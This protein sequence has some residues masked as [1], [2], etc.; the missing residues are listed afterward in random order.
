MLVGHEEDLL[1]LGDP[2]DDLLGVARGD[3]P[4]RERLHGRRAVDVGDGLEP[5]P[6][7]PELRLERARAGAGAAIG[8]AAT[9]PE[10][11]QEDPLVGVEHLG[12][13][14]HEVDPAEDDGPG[15]NPGRRPG[16][17]EAVAGDVGQLLDLAFL[18]I[19]GQDRGVLALLEGEDLVV[20]VGHGGLFL[21]FYVAEEEPTSVDRK[22]VTSEYRRAGGRV[23]KSQR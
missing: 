10:V 16:Q 19:M 6:L 5:P 13:L 4:V 1:V 3:D 20:D 12:R 21:V 14:G 17:L 18:V 23:G 22:P 8:Q 2:A 7:G 11:G 15:V 9:G